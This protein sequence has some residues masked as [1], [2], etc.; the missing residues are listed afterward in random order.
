MKIGIVSDTH[1]NLNNLAAAVE[2]LR[3][4]DVSSILHCGDLCGS[5]VIRALDGFDVW[6]AQGNMDRHVGLS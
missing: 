5:D 4:E 2:V 3:A 1:D 6:I